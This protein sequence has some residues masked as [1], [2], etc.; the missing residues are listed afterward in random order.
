MAKRTLAKLA[1]LDLRNEGSHLNETQ[2]RTRENLEAWTQTARPGVWRVAPAL[3]G[4]AYRLYC[5]ADQVF[6]CTIPAVHEFTTVLVHDASP[7]DV[8]PLYEFIRD[9]RR[10]NRSRDGTRVRV[11]PEE[12]ALVADWDKRRTSLSGERVR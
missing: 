1:P 6:Y 8:A 11:W 5:G 10:F 9:Q 12:I 4:E 7:Q 2:R 3:R